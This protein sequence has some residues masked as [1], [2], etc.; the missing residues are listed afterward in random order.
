MTDVPFMT[1]A[2]IEAVQMAR[3]G[4][5][6]AV[7]PVARIPRE[8][9]M[10]R[11]GATSGAAETVLGP[12]G[13]VTVADFEQLASGVR[14]MALAALN[15]GWQVLVLSSR[16]ETI[17]NRRQAI[18]QDAEAQKRDGQR[19][20]TMVPHRVEIEVHTVRCLLLGEAYRVATFIDGS[21]E[22]CWQWDEGGVPLRLSSVES[23]RMGLR[24]EIECRRRSLARPY[25]GAGV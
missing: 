10:P 16:A 2:R 17:R 7:M 1:R 12:M 22:R 20:F 18:V 21:F 4:V 11:Q 19:K 24:S 3:G 8:L 9:S 14:R 25:D 6:I 5:R 23:T 15:D 13:A